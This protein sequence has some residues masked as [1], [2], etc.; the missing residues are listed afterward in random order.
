MITQA[1]RKIV[2]SDR[3][4]HFF[5][6]SYL[7]ARSG[8]N[9][10]QKQNKQTATTTTTTTT[11]FFKQP[12]TTTTTTAAA[13]TTNIHGLCL[14]LSFF[15]SFLVLGQEALCCTFVPA[16]L[17]TDHGEKVKWERKQ[18]LTGPIDSNGTKPKQKHNIFILT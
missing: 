5:G 18:D 13:T 2:Q 14:C 16:I 9:D 8:I 1:P 11:I 6:R 17:N 4:W 12:K 3:F 15:L 10:V 7:F